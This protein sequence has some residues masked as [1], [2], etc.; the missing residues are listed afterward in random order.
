MGRSRRRLRP[1]H[2][3]S[4][5][6]L[7]TETNS[8]P[9]NSMPR[10]R[11]KE[12]LSTHRA[13]AM[14]CRWERT[15]FGSHL[16]RRRSN[17]ATVQAAISIVVT[18]ATPALSWP[19]PAG[20]IY[21]TALGDAQL[22]ASAPVP[23]S[24]DYSPAP[25]EVLPLERIHSRSRSPRRTPRTTSQLMPP[26][27]SPWPGRDLPS[28]GRNPMR[29]RTEPNSAPRNS[30]PSRRFRKVRI[31]PWGGS[32]VA[33]GE[34]RLSVV[35]TPGD[36][37]GYSAS[38]TTASYCRQGDSCHHVAGTGTD[39]VRHRPERDSTQCHCKRPGILN[40]RTCRRRDSAAGSA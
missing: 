35:F 10:H 23:G 15:R 29:S 4:P 19:T 20:I 1:S 34:H 24:F 13:Q 9:P 26:C 33:A 39:Y 5:T 18:K 16:I 12:P 40:L 17:R 28:N 30:L 32:G 3:R 25:G 6:R 36:T 8:P 14:C 38:Q 27:S 2:G 31:H 7:T 11:W 21:G 37:L 22:N